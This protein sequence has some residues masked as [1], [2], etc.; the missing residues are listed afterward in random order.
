LFSNVYVQR[1]GGNAVRVFLTALIAATG[2]RLLPVTAK[3]LTAGMRC[4]PSTDLTACLKGYWMAQG[5]AMSLT[6]VV[7][8]FALTA[9]LSALQAILY[10]TPA[11]DPQL[12]HKWT[13]RAG[14]LLIAFLTTGTALVL[15][16]R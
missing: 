6:V 1:L 16:T 10:A 4:M 7:L 11:F 3:R 15:L 9:L 5:V 12:T 8:A 13:V 14:S 2:Y